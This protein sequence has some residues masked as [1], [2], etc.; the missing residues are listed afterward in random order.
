M[1]FIIHIGICLM[2]VSRV[3]TTSGHYSNTPNTSRKW[4]TELFAD[5]QKDFSMEQAVSEKCRNDYLLYLSHLRNQ[6]VWAVRMKESSEWP[7]VGLYSGMVEH[8]GNWDGCLRASGPNDIAGK[9]CIAEIILK[10]LPVDDY[11][12]DRHLTTKG[13]ECEDCSAWSMLKKCS[14]DPLRADRRKIQWAICLPSSCS[15]ADLKKSLESVMIPIFDGSGLT[16]QVNLDSSMCSTRAL[17]PENY[18]KEYY[19]TRINTL[20]SCFFLT[21]MNGDDIYFGISGF[22]LYKFSVQPMS[23]IGYPFIGI[24][25][26]FRLLK[27]IPAHGMA[28]LFVA[29]MLPYL[30]DGPFWNSSQ[31]LIT[32]PCK[33]YWLTSLLAVNNFDGADKLCL[34][35]SWHLAVDFQNSLIGILL[36]LVL[37]KNRR[38]GLILI[39]LAF[40]LST[41][42]AGLVS[43]FRGVN[44]FHVLSIRVVTTSGHYSNTPNPSRKWITELFADSQKDFSMEQ[45]ASVLEH[46]GNWAGCLRAS[47]SNDIAGKYCI[48]EI[49]LKNLPIDDYDSDRHLTTR[50]CECEDCS[51]WSMLG[52][53]SNDPLRADRRKIQ[54]A[55]CLPSSCSSAD[56]KKS[57]ESVMIP[58]FD[59]SGLTVQINLDSSMCSTR[60]LEPEN[61]PKEY[62]ITRKVFLTYF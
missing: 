12:S 7:S 61:Y 60:A 22:L 50:G 41:I 24:Y 59:G 14:N 21:Q 23:K 44:G 28:I 26:V 38:L 62:Y 30:G 3:A 49:M 42:L 29:N 58:I 31:A 52:K 55:I 35:P 37:T 11:H 16:I 51:A 2:V 45:A 4:I 6:S 47:G 46:L 53:C 19:I 54:W 40:V 36:L 25:A 17:E 8:L 18:P 15:S 33:T 5:S 9:Y 32:Q 39:G 20:E 13:Y 48:A 10:N 43:Y 34:I 57:L 27:T 1:Y 56:L